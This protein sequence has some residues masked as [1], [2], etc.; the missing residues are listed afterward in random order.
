MW[1][2]LREIVGLLKKIL[3]A[4]IVNIAS[5]IADM[6]NSITRAISDLIA[7]VRD[8]AK[9]FSAFFVA[10]IIIG[11]LDELGQNFNALQKTLSLKFPNLKPLNLS[12][13]EK[14]SF[15]DFTA[16]IPYAGHVTIVRGDIMTQFARTAKPFFAGLFYFL[17][18]L[19]FFRKFHKVSED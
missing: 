12:I 17:T 10:D 13:Q 19:F 3:E 7:A 18:G 14:D 11:D 15:D 4:I 16:D 2:W 8:F 1:D 5:W 6:A 9:E